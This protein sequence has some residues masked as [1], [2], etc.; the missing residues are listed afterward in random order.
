[1]TDY[2]YNLSDFVA[3]SGNVDG[4]VLR[5]TCAADIPAHV[6]QRC[7]FTEDTT[8]PD[9]EFLFRFDGT[10]SGAEQTTLNGIV[11]AHLGPYTM[12]TNGSSY[13]HW[14]R[15][16]TTVSTKVYIPWEGNTESGT[17]TA[18]AQRA[19]LPGPFRL[20]HIRAWITGAD[21]MD[22][23]TF[24]LHINND[25]TAQSTVT[26]DMAAID[27]PYDFDFRR[28][29]N[30]TVEAQAVALSCDPATDPNGDVFAISVWGRATSM[31]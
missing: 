5:E 20:L 27:T 11:A 10:L 17:I 14:H 30:L 23:T 26:T 3:M 28:K 15:W 16:D 12:P 9:P 2:T 4:M 25:T 29:N 21:A 22:S 24:G 18:Q 8:A 7:F 31:W 13:W 19:F 6:L 1:M